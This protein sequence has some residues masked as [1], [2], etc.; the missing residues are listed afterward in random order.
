MGP[1]EVRQL[2]KAH[3]ASECGAGAGDSR[4]S[5]QTIQDQ[6]PLRQLLGVPAAD[7]TQLAPSAPQVS[8]LSQSQR[9]APPLGQ[10]CPRA[11]CC[12]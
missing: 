8:F 2:P 6:G 12:S 3:A 4:V 5:T 7:G 11:G 10:P 9:Q 1:R